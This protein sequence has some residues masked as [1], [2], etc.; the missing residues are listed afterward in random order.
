MTD[1]SQEQL[2]QLVRDLEEQKRKK[3]ESK[4]KWNSFGQGLTSGVLFMTI[5]F[6]I[7]FGT[8]IKPT[9]E[10]TT[11]LANQLIAQR[12]ACLARFTRYTVLW[13]A[14]GGAGPQRIP[15]FNGL[16][17]VT[18]G[19]ALGGDQARPAWFVPADVNVVFYGDPATAIVLKLNEKGQVISRNPPFTMSEVNANPNLLTGK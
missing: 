12:D 6:S 5:V 1:L 9:T 17:D 14:S 18:P 2:Q 10:S 19:Q 3:A 15:L 13:D 4:L 7:V 11:K 8:V 16:I